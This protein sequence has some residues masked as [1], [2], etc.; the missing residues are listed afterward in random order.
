MKSQEREPVMQN[1]N[2]IQ[3]DSSQQQFVDLNEK[4]IRLLAPAGAGKTNTLLYRCKSLLAKNPHERFLLFTFT[5]VASDELR[6]RLKTNPDFQ[7]LASNVTITTFASICHHT[8]F[9]VCGLSC[10]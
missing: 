8:F 6:I 9:K 1:T 5:R 4:Y 3:L 7:C 2:K 10:Y